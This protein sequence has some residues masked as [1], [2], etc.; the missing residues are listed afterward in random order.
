MSDSIQVLSQ[1][2][3]IITQWLEAH[4]DSKNSS[5]HV[6]KD[7]TSS[8]DGTK[9]PIEIS[10]VGAPTTRWYAVLVG[11]E[12]GVFCGSA[13]IPENVKGIPGSSVFKCSS[14]EEARE[15]YNSARRS[16]GVERV[17]IIRETL[18]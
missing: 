2:R 14:E 6:D 16:G 12:P 1:I 5:S 9:P 7:N 8:S 15:V 10:D 13:T 17:T 18:A 3:D 11:R 4:P